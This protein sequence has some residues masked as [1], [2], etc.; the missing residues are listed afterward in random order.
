MQPLEFDKVE[1]AFGG[2][3]MPTDLRTTAQ[4]VD[5]ELKRSWLSSMLLCWA[6]P[7]LKKGFS[8]PLTEEHL[9][10]L[11]ADLR[12]LHLMPLIEA[13]WNEQLKQQKPSLIR[14]LW[15]V[16]KHH[17]KK[18]LCW[19]V[20]S[21][22]L[23]NIGR[24]LLLKYIINYV[25]SPDADW[26]Q[27]VVIAVLLFFSSMLEGIGNAASLHCIADRSGAVFVASMSGLVQKK[28]LNLASTAV[29]EME[30]NLIGNDIMRTHENLKMLAI[31]PQSF[32][33]FLCGLVMLIYTLGYPCL[34]GL[35]VMLVVLCV[36][37]CIA[38]IN[39]RAEQKGLAESDKRLGIMRQ[40]IHGIRAIKYSAW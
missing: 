10:P 25:G 17:L 40:I 6:A 21:G 22:V 2:A 34:V 11:P 18:G 36:N 27:G 29:V 26:R 35:A 4:S 32:V 14:A 5:K 15:A 13:A 19:G 38:N 7:V 20:I 12:T 37:V 24:P 9:P 31:F 23:Y 30:G 1:A 28:S 16:T 39:K 3:K 8:T 33:G